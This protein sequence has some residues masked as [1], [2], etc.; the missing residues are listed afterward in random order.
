MPCLY[1]FNIYLFLLL[2]TWLWQ[3]FAAHGIFHCISWA[4]QLWHAGSVA[5][6][7]VGILVPW[8]EIKPRSAALQVRFFFLFFF[9]LKLSTFCPL[10]LHFKSLWKNSLRPLSGCSYL[11][12]GLST[13]GQSSVFSSGLSTSVFSGELLNGHWRPLPTCR[14]A[15]LLRL[16]PVNSRAGAVLSSWNSSLVTAF[17]A[18]RSADS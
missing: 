1:F 14:Q 3:V 7:H 16:V 18:A 12:S 10:N 13:A 8:L 4:L 11:V 15:G 2:L 5:P 17:S 6:W 9:F